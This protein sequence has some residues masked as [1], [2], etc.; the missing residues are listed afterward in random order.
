MSS[1]SLVEA[2]GRDR[3]GSDCGHDSAVLAS[4][5][6]ARRAAMVSSI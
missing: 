3:G 4:D 5:M 2:L 1:F 6:P